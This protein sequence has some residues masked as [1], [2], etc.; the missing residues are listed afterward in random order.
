MRKTV[1]FI[2][3]GVKSFSIIENNL[4]NKKLNRIFHKHR[5][6]KYNGYDLVINIKIAQALLVPVD[7]NLADMSTMIRL[8]VARAKK[9]GWSPSAVAPQWPGEPVAPTD[10]CCFVR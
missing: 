10:S 7:S 4:N 5:Q 8:A 9:A 3:L 1:N 6:R 2:T